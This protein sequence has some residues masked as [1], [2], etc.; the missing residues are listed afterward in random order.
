[1]ESAVVAAHI[2]YIE[3]RRLAPSTIAARRATLARMPAAPEAMDRM[4]FD[5]WWR[6]RQTRRDGA[7]MAARSLATELSHLRAFYRWA[8]DE[9]YVQS[10]PIRVG[11]APKIGRSRPNPIREAALKDALAHADPNMT[12]AL[13]L[14]ALAGLRASEIAA[15]QWADLDM[16][17]GILWV[18]HGKGDKDRSVPLSDP[19]IGY[20]GA[21]GTGPVVAD[22]DGQAISGKS[23]SERVARYLRSR[24]IN[25]TAHKLRARYATKHLEG[26]RN[27]ISTRDVLGHASIS[28][29]EGYLRATDRQA[30]KGA[31]A[32][33]RIG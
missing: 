3:Q 12:R 23:V 33:G 7:A 11:V 4:A 9:G 8:Q 5:E 10:N 26:Q 13:A 32:A 1:M 29:T 31:D 17:A 22:R 28:T 6:G 16:D 19:L 30:R 18:R 2:E 21:H 14:G 27:I 20:L 15:L 24:G 25:S